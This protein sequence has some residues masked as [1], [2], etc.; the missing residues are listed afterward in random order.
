M[1]SERKLAVVTIVERSAVR[2]VIFRTSSA[3][4]WPTS[5]WKRSISPSRPAEALPPPDPNAASPD[6]A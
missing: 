3:M 2:G 1:A 4:S 6:P 5:A